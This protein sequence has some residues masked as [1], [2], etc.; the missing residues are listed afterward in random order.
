M[1]AK[2]RQEIES[3]ILVELEETP[4]AVSSLRALSGGTANFVYD[5][6]LKMPL[7]DGTREVLIKHG[8]DFSAN[9]P[10]FKLTRLRCNIEEQC[11]KALSEFEFRIEGK[12]ELPCDVSFVVRT[13]KLYHYDEQHN[14]QIHEFLRNSKDLKTYAL[15]RY[16]ADTSED[17]RSQC[18]QL[19][20]ALG[21]WLRGFHARSATQ[22]GLRETVARNT[23]MQQLKNTIN[24]SWLLDRVA[25]FPSVLGEA[26]NVFE[27]VKAMAAKELED[28]SKLQVIHGDFWTGNILLSNTAIQKGSTVPLFV[29]DWEM[30]QMGVPSLD[31][32][33]MIAELYELKLYKNITAGLWIAQGFVLGYERFKNDDDD[34]DDDE[35]A[36]RTAIQVG[37]HLLSFGTSVEGWGTPE[38]VEMVARTG[39]DII[40]HAWKRDRKWFEGGNL[41]FLFER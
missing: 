23:A 26:M 19:G 8:E 21:G 11:L 17:A 2:S 5:A 13:P 36:F 20:R 27:E 34:D 30:S 9:A 35:F 32:G 25:Q 15:D 10:H 3:R 31:L 18:R 24:Y 1:A 38:Q 40:I 14:T 22:T 28:R 39:R 7:P 37:V 4:Y 41:A 6:T 16:G 33:Q 29:I 12:A